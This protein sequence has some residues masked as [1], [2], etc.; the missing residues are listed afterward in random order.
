[1]LV[2]KAFAAGIT[3]PALGDELNSVPEAGLGIIFSSVWRAM[4][5]LGGLALLMYLVWGGAE[6]VLA[7]GD[8]GKV[9]NARNKITQGII[10]MCILAATVAIAVFLSQVF[11]INLLAPEFFEPGDN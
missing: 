11:G 4:I 2:K 8:K 6:W 7:G 1:M 3:N 10:G 5:I 9:E